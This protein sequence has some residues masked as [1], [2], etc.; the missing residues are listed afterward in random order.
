[1]DF[2]KDLIEAFDSAVH[3]DFRTRDAGFLFPDRCQA[4]HEDDEL[5]WKMDRR[6]YSLDRAAPVT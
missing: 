1:M 6:C 5:R 2:K 3:Q 4:K